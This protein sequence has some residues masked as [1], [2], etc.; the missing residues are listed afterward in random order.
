MYILFSTLS[1]SSLLYSKERIE[2]FWHHEADNFNSVCVDGIVIERGKYM[3]VALFLLDSSKSQGKRPEHHTDV[4]VPYIHSIDLSL[5]GT[6]RQQYELYSDNNMNAVMSTDIGTKLTCIKLLNNLFVFGGDRGYIGIGR[7]RD[8]RQGAVVYCTSP[9]VPFSMSDGD[10]FGSPAKDYTTT[11]FYK[12]FIV[13]KGHAPDATIQCL[14]VIQD[15][16]IFA[17]GDDNGIITLWTLDNK[18]HNITAGGR[19]ILQAVLNVSSLGQQLDR[20]ERIRSLQFLPEEMSLLVTTNER[21]LY[22]TLEQRCNNDGNGDY[23]FD[24]WV[25]LD[26]VLPDCQAY[27]TLCFDHNN[28]GKRSIILWK[29]VG[30]PYFGP[31][32]TP[33][34]AKAEDAIIFRLKYD[35][36][37]AHFM[38]KLQKI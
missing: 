2:S 13:R 1:L 21:L 11:S 38:T 31:G 23:Y 15:A 10:S 19:M 25:E 4:H 3:H 34:P 18:I 6:D 14:D 28:N 8:F 22:V 16:G 37:F 30:E 35:D 7:I 27:F 12:E 36:L 17:G 24:K 33:L 32:S 5:T 26:S 20:R 29:I 9:S